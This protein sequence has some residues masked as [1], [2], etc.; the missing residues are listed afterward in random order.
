MH[1][2]ATPDPIQT[3]NP[4]PNVTLTLPFA[5]TL[6]SAVGFTPAILIVLMPD[7]PADMSATLAELALTRYRPVLAVPVLLLSGRMVS[8]ACRDSALSAVTRTRHTACFPQ[9]ASRA[10]APDSLKAANQ[11]A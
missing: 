6:N 8:G 10:T 7:G 4:A 2:V 5:T 9:T 11:E 3:I 1:C